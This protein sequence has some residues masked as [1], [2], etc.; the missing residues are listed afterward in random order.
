MMQKFSTNWNSFFPPDFR[1]NNCFGEYFL[2]YWTHHSLWPLTTSFFM[3]SLFRVERVVMRSF[4]SA[5][6]WAGG[7]LHLIGSHRHR[8]FSFDGRVLSWLITISDWVFRHFSFLWRKL[9][10]FN[11]SLFWV[12]C[13]FHPS[14]SG[15]FRCLNTVWRP[16]FEELSLWLPSR[17]AF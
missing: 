6:S 17:Q 10:G 5:H 8:R 1:R 16:N 13:S 3:C 9:W 11:R 2:L 7:F 14:F 12:F 15:A 4:C